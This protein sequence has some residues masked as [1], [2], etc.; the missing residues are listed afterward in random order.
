MVRI[1]RSV[2]TAMALGLAATTAMAAAGCGGRTLWATGDAGTNTNSNTNSNNVN[3]N[4]NTAVDAGVVECIDERCLIGIRTDNCCEAAFATTLDAVLQDPCLDVWPLLWERIP[5]ACNDA[6]DPECAYIDCMPGPPRWRIAECT[7][8]DDVC[9][10]VP[11][12]AAGTDCV[13]GVDHRK[14]CPCPEGLPPELVE[15]DPCITPY[16]DNGTT[17]PVECM[18]TMCPEM[19]CAVCTN[20]PP[21]CTEDGVCWSDNPGW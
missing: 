10:M 20:A 1:R 16:P 4:T 3:T 17:V 9:E 15:R 13:L 5:Q 21:Q 11:E 8:P 18:P 19:P 6:W 2:V 7:A 14:C 12:C